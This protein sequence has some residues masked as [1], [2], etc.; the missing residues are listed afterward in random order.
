MNSF[1]IKEYRFQG[2]RRVKT[3]KQ[4]AIAIS[5]YG[6]DHRYRLKN[7]EAKGRIYEELK[8]LGRQ[9]RHYMRMRVESVLQ[10]TYM[11]DYTMLGIKVLVKRRNEANGKD[12][13]IDFAEEYWHFDNV[14][15]QS[16][17]QFIDSY[18]K[19]TK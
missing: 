2:L 6:M 1:E 7:Y 11:L 15:K 10:L 5:N 8:L 16:E 9:Y 4:D 12:K 14:T 17:E 3:D 18:L 19:W 13:L